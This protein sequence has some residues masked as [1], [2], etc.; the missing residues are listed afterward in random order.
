MDPTPL[1]PL[2]GLFVNTEPA[3]RAYRRI[4]PL[5]GQEPKWIR[6]LGYM[7]IHAPR[8]YY[9]KFF[10]KFF[11][12]MTRPSTESESS[13]PSQPIAD[14]I[15][16]NINASITTRPLTHKHAKVNA[17]IR[18]N[19]RCAVTR[20]LELKWRKYRPELQYIFN[21][22]ESDG[23]RTTASVV[24]AI[25]QRYGGIQHTEIIERG[26]NHSSKILTLDDS[27]HS[28]FDDLV[29]WFD[30]VEGTDNTYRIGKKSD[31]IRARLP[32]TIT[33]EST[34]PRLS[35]PDRRYLALHAA[36]AKIG[37][38]SGAIVI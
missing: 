4:L 34:T 28:L 3:R 38:L 10:I 36:C 27:L 12:Q 23:K 33:F 5:E 1:P 35:L 19:F 29:I 30:P 32:E 25:L 18:D 26:I 31:G 13:H 17:L 11:Q 15:R 16:D 8:E 14:A 22:V 6:I 37:H 2:N 24:L 9:L 21:D 7:L 20:Q